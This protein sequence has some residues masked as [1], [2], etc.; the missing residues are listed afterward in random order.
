M[1][2]STR[3]AATRTFRCRMQA[4][5]LD[6]L[7]LEERWCP[8][9]PWNRVLVTGF[10]PDQMKNRRKTT[11][12]PKLPTAP[13]DKSEYRASEPAIGAWI[14]RHALPM[15]AA[16]GRITRCS[17][18]VSGACGSWVDKAPWQTTR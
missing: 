8:L 3:G 1:W 7:Q 17:Q 4:I 15:R 5:L 18:C 6:A 11:R 9:A 2:G 13:I 10:F 16:V 12:G 14:A